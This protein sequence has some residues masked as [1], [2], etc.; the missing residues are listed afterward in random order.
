LKEFSKDYWTIAIDQRGYGQSD[1]PKDVSDYH[2]NNMADDINAL[3]KYL[4]KIL[5]F[6]R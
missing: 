4:G 6:S 1:K 2:T 3:V 5:F